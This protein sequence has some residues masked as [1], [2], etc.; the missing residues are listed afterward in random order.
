MRRLAA[1]TVVVAVS[2]LGAYAQQAGEPRTVVFVCEHGAAK[3]VIAAAYFNKLAAERHL[4]A[5]AVAR[6]TDPQPELS[7]S[8]VAGLKKD[9]VAYPPDKPRAL[10]AADVR[11]ADHVIAFCPVP[12][13][14]GASKKMKTYDV[15]APKDG[16]D[17]SRDA[18]LK[19]VRALVDQ[20]EASQKAGK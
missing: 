2:F 12:E 9:G 15:P 16:Y 3:S 18:I 1:F 7:E 8:T 11:S 17:A 6:G 5:I 10:T 13:R 19:Q 20:I 4:N 14:L